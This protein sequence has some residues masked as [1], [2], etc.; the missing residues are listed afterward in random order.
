[1]AFFLFNKTKI[2]NM[3]SVLVAAHIIGFLIVPS[4]AKERGRDSA[5][6]I[7]FS[8]FFT[9]IVAIIL[10]MVIGVD[11]NNSQIVNPKDSL[12]KNKEGE[13][14]IY[15]KTRDGDEIPIT[16]LSDFELLSA[17]NYLWKIS[18]NTRKQNTRKWAKKIWYEM[19]KEKSRR[20][21]E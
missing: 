6:W 14:T 2:Y 17:M 18:H 7:A 4:M 21:F 3:V 8:V 20:I 15:W 5:S 19:E 10:L 1:M 11:A 16:C 13:S 9:S 12:S